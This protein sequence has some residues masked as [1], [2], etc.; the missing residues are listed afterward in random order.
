VVEM[1]FADILDSKVVDDEGDCNRAV[2]VLPQPGSVWGV[3]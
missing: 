3:S 1:L 2:D